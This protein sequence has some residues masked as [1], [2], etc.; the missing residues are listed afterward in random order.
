M[1]KG[2]T[3]APAPVSCASMKRDHRPGA[4]IRQSRQRGLALVV[5]LWAAVL[6]AMLATAVS[7]VA[8]EDV[9]LARNLV[10]TTRAELAA[11]SG[12][13]HALERMLSEDPEAYWDNPG[14]VDWAFGDS[15][16][17]I[18]VTDEIARID[19][20][21]ASEALIVNL[22]AA[23]GLDP[24][25]ADALVAAII[26]HRREG[27]PDLPRGAGVPAPPGRGFSTVEELMNVPG[28]T[29]P[30]FDL[31]S[32][33]ITVYTGRH[34]PQ[35]KNAKPLVIAALEGNV[36]E[37]SGSAATDPETPETLD[38]RPGGAVRRG[39]RRNHLVRFHSEARAIGG[40]VFAR[41]AVIL[42]QRRR[43]GATYQ[44]WL[45]RRGERRL[46]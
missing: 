29:R 5:V 41:E 44:I 11:D 15:E 42:V 19:I 34:M 45:W 27:A 30:L 10:D 39:R 1:P 38:T 16:I 13:H 28:M 24:G 46:F 12:L 8:R 40:S 6:L 3:A 26:A 17:R 4:T 7:R 22:F 25:A 14:I 32:G 20:N 43:I 37:D 21:A 18:S 9:V 36:L 2:L 23:V 35:R 31:V 33:A